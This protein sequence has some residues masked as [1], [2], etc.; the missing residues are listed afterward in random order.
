MCVCLFCVSVF[1]IMYM[2]F[3]L[4]FLSHIDARTSVLIMFLIIY[5]KLL[6]NIQKVWGREDFFERN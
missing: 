1:S 6:T 3:R 2:S 4:V 5:L